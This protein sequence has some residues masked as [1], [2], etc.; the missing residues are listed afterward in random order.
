MGQWEPTVAIDKYLRNDGD[1]RR[2]GVRIRVCIRLCVCA[3][4]VGVS[5][6][7]RRR[8]SPVAACQGH[9][10]HYAPQRNAHK[11]VG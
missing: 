1:C 5:V 4:S 3:E 7:L 10:W 11:I 2:G 6:K 9:R 8:L